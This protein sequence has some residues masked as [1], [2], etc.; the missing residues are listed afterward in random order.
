MSRLDPL[1]MQPPD[2]GRIKETFPNESLLT[3]ATVSKTT[4]YADIVNYLACRVFLDDINNQA[5]KKLMF[6][7]K[8]YFWDDLYLFK[9]CVNNLVRWC[10]TYDKVPYILTHFHSFEIGGHLGPSRIAHKVF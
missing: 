10:V 4:W 7:A 2:D 5:K 8:K 9:V 6:E 3:M 1:V